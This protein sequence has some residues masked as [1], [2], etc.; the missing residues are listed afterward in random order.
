MSH[1]Q[2]L[3][4]SIHH[5]PSTA[6][7]SVCIHV[8]EH[9]QSVKDSRGQDIK[10]TWKRAGQCTTCMHELSRS[11]SLSVPGARAHGRPVCTYRG[12]PGKGPLET[13][14]IQARRHFVEIA[15]ATPEV[16]F[17]RRD[18]NKTCSLGDVTMIPPSRVARHTHS[19]IFRNRWEQSGSRSAKHSLLDLS[20]AT[21]IFWDTSG[22]NDK[23]LF[24]SFFLSKC[25][26]ANSTDKA[27]DH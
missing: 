9:R 12:S 15:M 6:L 22:W 5:T 21:L 20:S 26:E 1:R 10:S 27:P 25:T 7:L 16:R 11:P 3:I 17:R 14:V 8:A 18:S 4:R 2:K 23:D 13:G 19:M 24:S